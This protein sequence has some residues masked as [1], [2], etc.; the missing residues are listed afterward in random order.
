VLRWEKGFPKLPN[1]DNIA[2]QDQYFWLNG[3]K[4]LGDFFCV[5]AESSQV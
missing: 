3:F 2:I 5:T 4:V 1:V